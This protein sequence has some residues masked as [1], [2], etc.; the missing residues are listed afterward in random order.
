MSRTIAGLA[1]IVVCS[2]GCLA[3][4][5][6][7]SAPSAPGA[8]PSR[9]RQRPLIDILGPPQPLPDASISTVRLRVPGKARDL[10]E[11]ARKAYAKR[12]YEE[13]ERALKR[14]LELYPAF[15]EALTMS[16]YIQI[17]LSEWQPAEQSLQTAVRADPTYGLAQI[18]LADLYNTEQRFEDALAVA[19][20]AV[21][22]MPDSSWVIQFEIARGLLGLR[23]DC[24]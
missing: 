24:V 18:V 12:R 1:G 6:P 5:S 11:K 7:V 3:Q 15:P 9:E 23:L 10:Y 20:R 22:G 16:G 4:S 13:A 19:R 14:A 21:A 2:I 8:A 17:C